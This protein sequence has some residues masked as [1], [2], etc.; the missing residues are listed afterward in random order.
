MASRVKPIPSVTRLDRRPSCT[1]GTVLAVVICGQQSLSGVFRY[2]G[3]ADN[4][5]LEISQPGG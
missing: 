5:S 2:S 1:Q 3:V 4:V